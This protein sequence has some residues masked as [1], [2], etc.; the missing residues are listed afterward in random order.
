VAK[1]SEEFVKACLNMADAEKS[2]L[3][4]SERELYGQ[5]S[6]KLKTFLNNVCS[7]DNTRYLELGV[8]RGSTIVS[9][10]Y[11]N[12]SLQALGIENFKYDKKEP[13]YFMEEGWPNMKSQMYDV[14]QKYQFV[15]DVNTDNLKIIES[16]FQDV[17]WSSQAKFDVIFMDIDPITPEIY[18]SFF[19]K[20]F[21]AFSRHCIVIFS[22]YSS[23]EV[24]P[25]L[26][27]KVEQYSD[28]VVTEFKF[29]RISSGN[30]DSFGYFSGI[31]IYGFRKKAF[32]KND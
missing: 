3:T 18:D 32:A 23:E 10:M 31:A 22:N 16:D 17:S 2:K 15:D 14:F 19:K 20:V 9:S 21:N 27:E 5:S 7:K 6:I 4:D 24:A 13:K 11:G 12:N 29:Q 8:Y 26:E 28:R 1:L 30:A 25:L